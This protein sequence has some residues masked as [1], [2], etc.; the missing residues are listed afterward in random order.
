MSHPN[1]WGA[2]EQSFLRDVV[3]RAG[4]TTSDLA[5]SNIRFVTDTDAA[6]YCYLFNTRLT[7]GLQTGDV[8]LLCDA[9]NTITSVSLH[10]V[11]STSPILKLNTCGSERLEGGASLVD[12][13][14]ERYMRQQ[15]ISAG[16]S[17]EDADDFT[18]V[19]IEDFKKHVKFAF[20]DET[21]EYL[22]QISK[23]PFNDLALTGHMGENSY[24][25]RMIK[26]SYGNE[27]CRVILAGRFGGPWEG[28]TKIVLGIDI[29]T[30]RS[31]VAFAFLQKGE[32]QVIHHV[33]K[34]LG[35]EAQAYDKVPT[36][37][38][39]DTNQRAV[40]FG[41]E[42]QLYNT[43]EQAEN[44]G[45][46]LAKHFK[47]RLYPD[48]IKTRVGKDLPPG[49]SL[50]QIYSDFL[51]YLLEYTRTHFED[52][53]LDGK[54]IWQKFS[55]EMEVV[56][57]HPNGWGIREQAF[58]RSA[59]IRA[60]LLTTD[61]AL[62]QV[63]FVAEAEASVH[64]CIHHANLG[65]RL[66]PGTNVLV[67]DAGGSTVDTTLYSVILR[68]STL[69]L[70]EKRESTC[71]LAGAIFVDFEAEKFL[72]NH[73]AGTGLNEE[74]IAEY[75]KAGVKDFESFAKRVF[76]NETAQQSIVIGARFTNT[77]IG[78]RRGRMI[79]PGPIIKGFFDV[80]IKD[81]TRSVDEQLAGLNIPGPNILYILLVGGFG[82]SPY[83]RQEFTKRYESQKCSLVATNDSTSKA[84][85]D[86]AVLWYTAQ[87]VVS[88]R[89]RHSFGIE[90]LV[91][92]DHNDPDHQGRKG[93]SCTLACATV[94]GRWN[95]LVR[96]GV[97][98]DAGTIVRIPFF[99]DFSTPRPDPGRFELDLYTY[100]GDD[101]P[102]WMRNKQ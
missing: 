34:W 37:I 36:L 3:V 6:A 96:K 11:D 49:V 14:V 52:H 71:V 26:E 89:P 60:G 45:W 82:D 73:L 80:C 15:M 79:I 29:G 47:L 92:Y 27:G 4:Y 5:I 77:A 72:R 55:P 35:R 85:A 44:N 40:S 21:K 16:I 99:L 10:R 91:A 64:F 83:L 42:A 32:N 28:E 56:L 81:I 100:S 59:V 86:G 66:Q 54:D 2:R 101:E 7:G 74:D 69:E 76:D 31:S 23:M 20:G 30:T 13:A 57:A 38:W 94:P 97:P 1:G 51:G 19:G 18:R 61:R 62:S 102:M 70:E 9:G 88:R 8:F 41:A 87:R 25:Q 33:T 50:E 39:Y 65:S 43:E 58:L 12:D 53:I 46:F 67:C 75:V 93:L 24:L 22:V 84:V 78:I 68:G 90:T 17:T 48:K 63:R 95:N 98:L